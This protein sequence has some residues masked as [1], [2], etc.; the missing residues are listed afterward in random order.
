M[1]VFLFN[2]SSSQ[3][4]REFSDDLSEHEY[5][6]EATS[7]DDLTSHIFDRNLSSTDKSH[8][9]DSVANILYYIS[10][11]CLRKAMS[12]FAYVDKNSEEFKIHDILVNTFTLKLDSSECKSL[13][14]EIVSE[15]QRSCN[16]L[17]CPV[18]AIFNIVY[19]LECSIIEPF[20]KNYT[21]LASVGGEF[22]DIIILAIKSSQYYKEFT[23]I[24]DKAL[25]VH[26][27]KNS[28]VKASVV[29]N[30]VEKFFNVF[31]HVITTDS[32]KFINTK[33]NTAHNHLSKLSF[34]MLVY[35]NKIDKGDFEVDF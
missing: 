33:L 12:L 35:L 14:I 18:S 17:I 19:G 31:C 13:P 25:T 3:I 32:I 29:K 28:D 15:R 27:F 7:H 1:G 24:I 30:I 26:S 22:Y 10:G 11:F 8:I 5:Y 4:T 23:D 6:R 9:H 2:Q 16:K 20:M 34:R 21:L